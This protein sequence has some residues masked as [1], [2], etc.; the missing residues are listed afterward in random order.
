MRNYRAG[1]SIPCRVKYVSLC[2][3]WC[4]L[5]LSAFFVAG[6]PWLWVLLAAIGTGVTLHLRAI[7]AANH[8]ATRRF[9]LAQH[10]ADKEELQRFVADIAVLVEYI[11]RQEYAVARTQAIGLI[12]D[13]HFDIAL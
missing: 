2:S 13:F 7:P 11:A 4:T 10:R 1:L 9:A 8:L 6:M 5:A 3:L 12:T